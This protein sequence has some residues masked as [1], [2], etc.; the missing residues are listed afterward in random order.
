MIAGLPYPSAVLGAVR[1]R[2]PI[3]ARYENGSGLRSAVESWRCLLRQS[4]VKKISFSRAILIVSPYD[5]QDY[6]TIISGM[7]LDVKIYFYRVPAYTF[8]PLSL[9]VQNL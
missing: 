3:A 6:G 4:A 5:I 2:L 1:I 9:R 8:P 7:V